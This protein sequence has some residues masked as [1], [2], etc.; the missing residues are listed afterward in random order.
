M[1]STNTTDKDLSDA[2]TKI[3]VGDYR[4]H[5]FLCLGPSCCSEEVGNAAWDALKSELKKS[6]LG[7]LCHRTKAG[8]LRICCHGPTMVVYPE[9]TWYH[10]M[11]PDR[12]ERF[13]QEHLLA[14]KPIEEWIFARNPLPCPPGIAGAILGHVLLPLPG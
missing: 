7:N 12:I 3:G 6:G 10:D 14:D 2:A 13:V 4:R 8:C 9:G 11:T 1:S 5:V